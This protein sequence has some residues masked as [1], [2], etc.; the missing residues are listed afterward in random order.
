MIIEKSLLSE[1]LGIG[2]SSG[3]DFAEVFAENTLQSQMSLMSG[4]VEEISDRRIYGMGFRLL[5]GTRSV[6][7]S[8]SDMSRAGLIRC[9][10]RAAEAM[11]EIGEAQTVKLTERIFPDIHPVRM[12]PSSVSCADQ[13][14]LLHRA[15]DSAKAYS[16]EIAQVQARLLNVDRNILVA[17]SEGL[18]TGDRQVRTRLSVN[19]VASNGAENQSGSSSPGARKGLE[20]FDGITPEET[21]REAARQAV[22]ML[23]AGY[24][25]AGN[26]AVVIDNGFGGVIFHEACGHSLEATSVATGRSQFCGK[27]G[28]TVASP[29]VTAIDDGTEPNSWGSNNIDDEGRP[30]QK[31]VLI[32]NGILKNYLIDRLGSRRMNMPPTGCGRRENYHYEPTSRMSNTYIAAGKDDPKEIIGSTESGLYAAAMGGGSVNPVTGEFN[33]AV[34]EAYMIRNGEIAEPVRGATLI[35]IGSEIRPKIDRVSSN[36][37][38]AQG[39]C[40]SKS[41]S[42]PTNVGQP[43]IRVSSIT[44]GGR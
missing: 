29:I 7:A 31:L 37:A 41:G 42:I 33:F 15:C 5:K 44:V 22:T 21:G 39:M 13:A 18:L 3:A 34:R 26:M 28:E 24:A 10:R 36:L 30:T 23:H 4:A 12:V 20:L 43:M 6:F 1:L 35:G 11:G 25:P 19:A 16:G 40:G 17:N 27:L 14:Y 8:T 38:S 32:E 9:A 2:L